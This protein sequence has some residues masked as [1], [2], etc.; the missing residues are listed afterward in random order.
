MRNLELYIHTPFCVKKCE[1]CDFL[2]F[3]S[4]DNTQ[5]RYVHALLQEIKYY[6]S[7][8]KNYRGS[9]IYIGRGTPSWLD[10]NLTTTAVKK[11]TDNPRRGMN[12]RGKR[13][14]IAIFTII[15]K[16]RGV[17]IQL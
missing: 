16:K 1:Y 8:R 7:L 2:S 3:S 13:E 14:K 17:N 6:G 10:D 4:D 9:T 15:H 5:A 11:G 12:I